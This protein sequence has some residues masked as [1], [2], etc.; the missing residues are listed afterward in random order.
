MTTATEHLQELLNKINNLL[1]LSI[2][3]DYDSNFGYSLNGGVNG[4]PVNYSYLTIQ[5]KWLTQKEMANYL[6]GVIYGIEASREQMTFRT[7]VC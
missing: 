5:G 1:R 4:L 3:L 6:L 7:T 2:E